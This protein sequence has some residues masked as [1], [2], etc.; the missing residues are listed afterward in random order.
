MEMDLFLLHFA[1]NTVIALVLALS[2]GLALVI[3]R[4]CITTLFRAMAAQVN[5]ASKQVGR[6]I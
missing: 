4:W 2:F 6:S 5:K 1:I 3:E